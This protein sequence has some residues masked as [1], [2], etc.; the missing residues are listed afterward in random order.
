MQ[1]GLGNMF[2]EET[3]IT[4][5]NVGESTKRPTRSTLVYFLA[6]AYGSSLGGIGTMVGS[7]TNL[8]M[9]GILEK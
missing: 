5:E 1:Q 6:A 3:S 8:T 7:G 9:K 2:I 4:E